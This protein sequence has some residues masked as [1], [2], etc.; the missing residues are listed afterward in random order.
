M[1]I[2][3]KPSKRELTRRR[4][5]K[6]AIECI[7]E[8]GFNAAHT[9]RIAE[10]AG[11]S[12]GVLQ[13]HFGDKD[14]L[15]QAVLDDSFEDFSSTLRGTELRGDTLRERMG[16]LIEVVWS[17]VSKRGY[18]VTM[19]ILRNAGKDD[20]STLNGE[21]QVANWTRTTSR[22]WDRLFEDDQP[23]PQRSE[24]ARHLVFATLRGMAD[25]VNPAGRSS[26]AKAREREAL[27][28]AITFLLTG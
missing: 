3:A 8:H 23:D 20:N 28:E 11:V 2:S 17:L 22:L 10:A 24:I 4:V 25:E 1:S 7:Y 15:L 18:R 6:A 13:Y 12:W 27:A 9:N 5:I 16:Y 21:K 14:G 19:A 26:K